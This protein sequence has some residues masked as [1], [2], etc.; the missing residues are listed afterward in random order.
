M[1]ERTSVSVESDEHLRR[2]RLDRACFLRLLGAGA[3]LSMF[4]ASLSA[5]AGPAGAQAAAS[6]LPISGKEYPIGIWWPPPPDPPPDRTLTEYYAEISAANFNVVI[7]GNG[8]VND[9][10]N[11]PALQAAADNGLRFLLTDARLRN[12]IRDGGGTVQASSIEKSSPGIMQSL[13]EQEGPELRAA[14]VS[15]DEVKQRV[16]ELVATYSTYPAFAGINIYDEPEASMFELVNAAEDELSPSEELPYINVWPSYASAGALGARDYKAYLERYFARINPPLLCFD[17]YPLLKKGITS[18]Y[19]YNWAVIRN[20]A[21]RF[22]VPS[23]GYIQSVGFNGS[24]VG[25]ANRRK[26]NRQEILW[27]VNVS[28]AYGAKGI[29]YFT[30]WTPEAQPGPSIRFGQAL[31]SDTGQQTELYDYAREVNGYL[32]VVGKVILPLVS[33]SVVHARERRLPMGARRFRGDRH[34]REVSGSPVILGQ[35]SEEG[36]AYRYLLVVN[37]SF[38]NVAR[39]RLKM[40]VNTISRLN[41]TTGAFDP[42][43]LVG[44]PRRDLPMKLPPGGARLYRLQ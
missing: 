18:D 43:R 41:I 32:K 17:H 26:P 15:G 2:R 37:R 3:G 28:L 23:W 36:T 35:F 31:I 27:Q 33:E 30:Y 34:V 9:T 13:L 5:L 20:F 1:V 14:A 10:T 4:P 11:P 12:L 7:G 25:L 16:R 44:R 38:A 8:I 19:F 22:G 21:L 29:Q 24:E 40:G 42:V 39:T 6:G